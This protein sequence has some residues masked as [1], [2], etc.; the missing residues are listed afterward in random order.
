MVVVD[1]SQIWVFAT[2]LTRF[3]HY[4]PLVLVH[5]LLKRGPIYDVIALRNH[6]IS[7]FIDVPRLD[8][9]Q[10]YIT[11]KADTGT[12]ATLPECP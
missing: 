3:T 8:D 5:D 12:S 7:I 2:R 1:S 6:V 9:L 11:M 10:L 4:S